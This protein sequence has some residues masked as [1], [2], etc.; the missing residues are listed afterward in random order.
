MTA[1][2]R[3]EKSS[4]GHREGGLLQE[5]GEKFS[6]KIKPIRP[7]R[8]RHAGREMPLSAVPG[9]RKRF[10]R[11]KHGRCRDGLIM[12]AVNQQHWRL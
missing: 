12:V 8:V 3:G 6:A 5:A 9:S 2:Q 7:D 4:A 1:Q 11:F 10:R